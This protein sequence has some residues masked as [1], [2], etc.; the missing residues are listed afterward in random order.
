MTAQRDGSLVLG[1]PEGIRLLSPPDALQARLEALVEAGK[2]AVRAEDLSAYR[3]A[4]HNLA[5]LCAPGSPALGAV[6][7]AAHDQ[8]RLAPGG[9]APRLHLIPELTKVV[10]DQASPDDAERLR[11]QLALRELRRYKKERLGR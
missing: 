3:Q 2:A 9:L 1:S 7:H 8:G 6:N 11:A 4:A 10:Q 5:F